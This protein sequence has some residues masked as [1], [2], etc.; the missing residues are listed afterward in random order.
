MRPRTAQEK[1]VVA[2]SAT[3][4]PITEKEIEEA[5]RSHCH[6]YHSSASSWCDHCGYVWKEDVKSG[7]KKDWYKCPHCGTKLYIKKVQ[8]KIISYDQYYF[9]LVRVCGGYQVVRTFMCKR[10]SRR[11]VGVIH[12]ECDEVFQVWMKPGCRNTYM[13]RRVNGMSMYVDSWSMNTP[14][15]LKDFHSRYELHGYLAKKVELLPVVKRN[16]LKTIPYDVHYIPLLEGVLND[17]Q[18]E[19]LLKHKAWNLI[20]YHLNHRG[21]DKDVFASI[22]VALRRGYK[23]SDVDSWIDMV[24]MLNRCGK[25]TRSPRWICPE[26][27]KAAHDIADRMLKRKNEKEELARIL[28]EDGDVMTRFVERCG[29]WLGVEIVSGDLTI[30]PLQSLLDFKREGDELN[31]CVFSNKY[32]DREYALILGA[33]VKGERT[34]TI[35]IDTRDWRVVQ[36][37][38]KN[39]GSSKYHDRILATVNR[40]MNKFR[41]VAL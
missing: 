20:K 3:L 27:V 30:R 18:I 36:C 37:R 15:S 2:L 39:N 9:A 35:E 31:H 19:I 17:P 24:D 14:M 34:E 25:D 4:P 10:S 40:N 16:G 11:Q 13:A 26:D 1:E 21:I 23:I 7:S 32:Y 5:R 6:M 8:R 12:W 41:R 33:R 22:R 28:K 29:K 38:G